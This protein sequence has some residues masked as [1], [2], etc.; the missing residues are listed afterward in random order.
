[1]QG[2]DLGSKLQGAGFNP[3]IDGVCGRP[4][5]T[6]ASTVYCTGGTAGYGG[7]NQV[8][9]PSTKTAIQSAG[10]I[11]IGLGTNDAGTPASTFADEVSQMIAKVKALNPTAQIYWINM[12]EKKDTTALQALDQQ[13]STLGSQKGF[14]IIDWASIA[15]STSDAS[16][17]TSDGIH[18]ADFTSLTDLVVKTVGGT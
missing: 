10:T 6:H 8:D 3:T 2:K 4:L 7:L 13:L 16:K 5:A 1:M 9:Q 18:P 11:V 15:P 12:L 14:T 17:W